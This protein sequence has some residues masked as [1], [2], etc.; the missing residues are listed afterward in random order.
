MRVCELREKRE[1][2]VKKNKKILRIPT[3]QVSRDVFNEVKAIAATSSTARR[4]FEHL[5]P[6]PMS[7]NIAKRRA[8]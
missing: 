3:F 7:K 5:Q 8:S 6:K 2:P 1:N 4:L